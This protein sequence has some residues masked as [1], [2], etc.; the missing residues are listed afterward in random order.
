[1]AVIISGF[2]V[3]MATLDC[4]PKAALN[5]ASCGPRAYTDCADAGPGGQEKS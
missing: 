3:V 1:M 2:V 5:F 4:E